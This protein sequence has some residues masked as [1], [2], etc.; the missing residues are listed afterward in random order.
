MEDIERIDLEILH[1]KRKREE[2]EQRSFKEALASFRSNITCSDEWLNR[3]KRYFFECIRE[4][5]A[6]DP[7]EYYDECIRDDA[8][9]KDCLLETRK[10]DESPTF[11]SWRYGDWRWCTDL[12]CWYAENDDRRDEFEKLYVHVSGESVLCDVCG[13]NLEREEEKD[14]VA[15]ETEYYVPELRDFIKR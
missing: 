13:M 6:E 4:Q 12:D 11:M 10:S 1:L 15:L 7:K 2:I 5:E 14:L 8:F 3:S 9:L